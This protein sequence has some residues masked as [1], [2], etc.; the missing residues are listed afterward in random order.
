M[1]LLQIVLAFPLSYFFYVF[2][3]RLTFFPFL[4]FIGIF[5]IFALGADD[6]FVAVDKW[7][8]ARLARPNAPPHEIA[9]KAFPD[10]AG[11]MLLTT[12]TTAV[13]FFGTCV[14]PVSPILCFA[15]FVGM[16]VIGDYVLCCLLVFPA[17]VMYD[18]SLQAEKQ[19][20]CCCHCGLRSCCCCFVKAHHTAS[21]DEEH[22]EETEHK[23]PSPIHRIL[24]HYYTFLHRFRWPLLAIC[25]GALITSAVKA[26]QIELPVS[27]DVRLFDESDNQF[28]ANYIQRQRLLF[29]VIESKVGSTTDVIW[30]VLPADTGNHNNPESWTKLKLD[31]TFEPS[32]EDV[33]VFLRD[34]CDNFFAQDFASPIN[35]NYKCAMNQ[36]NE[37]LAEQASAEAP[38]EIYTENCAGVAGLPIPQASFD[39]CAYSWS[40]AYGVYDVLA[41][42]GKITVLSMEF[43]SR[44]RYD[45]PQSELEHEWNLIND[46]MMANKGP[47]G[48]GN[49]YFT[50]EDFWWYDTNAVMLKTACKS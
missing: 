36:L 20:G 11:A 3:A 17:L 45:S 39:A 21:G 9:A 29:E 14:C 6:V 41:K 22:A 7:K 31:P 13:A 26:A 1:G 27:A 30:G 5:V 25:G 12:L 40:Q 37:W 24:N 49:P 19:V 48:A 10:A 28:E 35:S 8:N 50:S 46:W 4:N 47:D 2:V 43:S 33:Q 16:L 34:F 38:E 32:R 44:I 23:E 18:N 15:V 42:A